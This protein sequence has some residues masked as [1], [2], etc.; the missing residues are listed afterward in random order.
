MNGDCES[1]IKDFRTFK[2]VYKGGKDVRKYSKRVKNE[3]AGCELSKILMDS[4]LNVV[5]TH[6]DTSINKAH[7]EFSPTLIN[8]STLIYA[9]LKSDTVP[10]F[11][12]GDT[13]SKIPVRKFYTAKK[14]WLT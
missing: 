13:S 6:L 5:I 1:S 4:A 7:V 14:K 10:Y 12:L 2:K 3:V 9:S 11:S 8:D